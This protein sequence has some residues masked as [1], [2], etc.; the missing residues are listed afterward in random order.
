MSEPL[1]NLLGLLMGL[2]LV[3]LDEAAGIPLGISL[4]KGTVGTGTL[5]GS[6]FVKSC[7]IL[8][9]KWLRAINIFYFFISWV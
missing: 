5:A 8:L 6:R 1:L 4:V 7:H 9:Y 2:L 3:L